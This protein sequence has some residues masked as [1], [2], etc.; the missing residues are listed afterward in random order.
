MAIPLA[1]ASEGPSTV[2][3]GR[4][5]RN[6]VRR[7]SCEGREAVGEAGSTR[8][9]RPSSSALS[10]TGLTEERPRAQRQGP[11]GIREGSGA[12]S[13]GCQRHWPS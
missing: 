2:G 11:C 9:V 10:P 12:L 6:G 13:E 4:T 7:G 3:R 1:F 8:P 5:A